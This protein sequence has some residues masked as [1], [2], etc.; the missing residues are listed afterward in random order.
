MDDSG[1]ITVD[2]RRNVVQL[3]SAHNEEVVQAK[4][5]LLLCSVTNHQVWRLSML[6]C[7][8]QEACVRACTCL[9]RVQLWLMLYFLH[10][11]PQMSCILAIVYAASIT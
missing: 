6:P 3:P 5:V 1:P 2:L 7:W 4:F 10:I 11:N 9:V 8:F